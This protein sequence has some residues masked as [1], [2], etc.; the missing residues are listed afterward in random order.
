MRQVYQIKMNA[1]M[2]ITDQHLKKAMITYRQHNIKILIH[3]RSH[4]GKSELTG[5]STH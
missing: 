2:M 1:L 4:F 5:P 3:F